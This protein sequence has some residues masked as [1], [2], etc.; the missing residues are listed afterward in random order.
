[1]NNDDAMVGRILTRREAMAMAAR[2]GLV[3]AGASVAGCAR[4]TKG[5][6]AGAAEP[7]P[8]VADPAMARPGPIIASPSVTEGPFFVDEKLNRSDLVAGTKRAA[9]VNG[10]PLS[11][12]LVVQKIEE[13]TLVPMKDAWVDVWHADTSGAYSDEAD[14]MNR[15]NTKGQKWL[16]GVSGDG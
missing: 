12:A 13:G 10:L 4:P 9:V 8:L 7:D 3:L 15:E 11:L 14:R 2:A 6:P 5:Q 1:M 16:V